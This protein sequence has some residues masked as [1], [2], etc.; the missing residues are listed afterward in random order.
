MNASSMDSLAAQRAAGPGERS[1][2]SASS[3]SG[4]GLD[5]ERVDSA[6]G[7]GRLNHRGNLLWAT[8][9]G[10]QRVQAAVRGDP[11]KPR[12][13]RGAA[14]ERLEAAPGGHHRLLHD[15]LGVLHRAED[16][17]GVHLKLAPVWLRELAKRALV[18]PACPREHG[19]A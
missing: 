10:A 11:I 15:V 13:H 17:V 7:L 8:P 2:R 1:G 3:T 5:P 19:L 4:V 18:P 16:A 6:G 14:L 9:P 12:A